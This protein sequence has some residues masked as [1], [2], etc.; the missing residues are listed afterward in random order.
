MAAKP[1][2][3][4]FLDE[5]SAV[6]RAGIKVL[7][8]TGDADYVSNWFGTSE[9]AHKIDWPGRDAFAAKDLEPYT[10]GGQEKASFKTQDNLTYMLVFGAGHQMT[11]YRKCIVRESSRRDGMC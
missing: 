10:V 3:R 6:V 9:V 1:D 11:W 2:A 4:S 8:W 7:I 5:L